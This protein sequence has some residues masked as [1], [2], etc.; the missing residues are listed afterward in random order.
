MLLRIRILIWLGVMLLAADAWA[1]RPNVLLILVDDLGPE[2]LSC[3]GGGSVKTPHLDALAA[4]GTRFQ[5]CYATPLCSTTRAML[6]TG[7]YP[8][9]TGW[10]WHHDPSVYGGGGFDWD[11]YLTLGRIF[12]QAGYATSIAGKW[13]INNLYEQ[14]EALTRH[15]FD[16]HC[17]W[18]GEKQGDPT[19][20]SR[21]WDPY[22]LENGRAGQRVGKFGE[23][24]FADFTI[25]F[26]RRHRDR[27]FL[28]YHAMHLTHTPFTGTPANSDAADEGVALFPGMVRY[29]DQVIGRLLA[30]LDELGLRD[31]TIVLLATDNG[32]ATGCR[33]LMNGR[34]VRGGKG[35]LLETGI[36]VPLIF[37]GTKI[38]SGQVSDQPVDFTDLLPTLVDLCGIQ[39]SGASFDGRSLAAILTGK[40]ARLPDR[41]WAHTQYGETRVVRDRRYKL[42]STGALYDLQLDPAEKHNLAASTEPE[43]VAARQ[44]LFA[45]LSGFPAA[46]A[47]LPFQPRSQSYFKFHPQAAPKN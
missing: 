36:Q 40:A 26:M 12:Q 29:A 38:T 32:S 27:P 6:L 37:R 17:V 45:A 3:Y 30:A 22:I 19:T 41:D 4:A 1:A 10:I 18:P 9:S 11:R 39:L 31:N 43:I 46:N 44:R 47:T 15:G 20:E 2:W 35:S 28:A 34:E 5:T 13:Q 21:Y 14:P 23:D 42:D 33:G 8:R 25:D 16:Q 7:Q 24:V